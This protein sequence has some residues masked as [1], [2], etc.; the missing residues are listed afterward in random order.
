MDKTLDRI[1]ERQAA[2]QL[3]RYY[4]PVE[5][6]HNEYFTRLSL[7]SDFADLIGST[8]KPLD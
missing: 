1:L 5:A 4:V 3:V 8:V 6:G 7:A 2:D